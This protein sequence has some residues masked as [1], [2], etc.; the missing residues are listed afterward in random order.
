MIKFIQH[1]DSKHNCYVV[2]DYISRVSIDYRNDGQVSIPLKESKYRL[3]EYFKQGWYEILPE[4][5]AEI[6]PDCPYLNGPIQKNN[7]CIDE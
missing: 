1:P 4:E 2:L 6:Q 7:W 5:A 3:N